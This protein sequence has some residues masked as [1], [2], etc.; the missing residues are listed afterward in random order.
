MPL[1]KKKKTLTQNKP[2]TKPGQSKIETSILVFMYG[3]AIR[4]ILDPYT[5]ETLIG[6]SIAEFVKYESGA[7]ATKMVLRQQKSLNLVSRVRM[8]LGTRQHNVRVVDGIISM[9][10]PN[11]TM[12]VGMQAIDALGFRFYVESPDSTSHSKQRS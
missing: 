6:E 8:E 10:L 9:T 1:P 2:V 5:Q 3:K 12:V 7:K 11:N 4:A